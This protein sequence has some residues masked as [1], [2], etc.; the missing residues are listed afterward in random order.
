MSFSNVAIDQ[1][2]GTF[3]LVYTSNG[4]LMPLPNRVHSVIL[5]ASVKHNAQLYLDGVKFT[6]SPSTVVASGKTIQIRLPVPNDSR[7]HFV[8]VVDPGNLGTA[9]ATSAQIEVWS[10]CAGVVT[11]LVSSTSQNTATN[12]QFVDVLMTNTGRVSQTFYS[13]LKLDGQ[14]IVSDI[15][16]TPGASTTRRITIPADSK[17]H[18]VSA[19]VK[20][21]SSYSA[22]PAL[23]YVVQALDAP[24]PPP[25]PSGEA[26]QFKVGET[27]IVQS[28]STSTPLATDGSEWVLLEISPRNANAWTP[29]GTEAGMINPQADGTWSSTIETNTSKFPVGSQWDL[30][31][32]RFRDYQESEEKRHIF[33]MITG[34]VTQISTPTVPVIVSPLNHSQQGGT[35][36]KLTGTGKPGSRL[37]FRTQRV[38]AWGQTDYTPMPTTVGSN[39]KW[40]TL[41]YAKKRD[42]AHDYKI[43][44][45]SC[46][47]SQNGLFSAYSNR[48]D[49]TWRN[50]RR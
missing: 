15:S 2:P 11:H 43:L 23:W 18:A 1:D 40:E 19:E 50:P 8:K 44:G 41:V 7:H 17:L 24:A 48:L 38:T 4:V 22:D 28:A 21:G 29:V 20:I 10:D 35:W 26:S 33:N 9:A 32:R 45:Y 37:E 16:L 13:R 5:K 30:R 3:C 14:T 36:V 6:P 46:R 12:E 31:T 39:G 49:I 25:D 47:A 42:D 34:S 27:I